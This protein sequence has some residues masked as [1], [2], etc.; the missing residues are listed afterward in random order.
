MDT[1]PGKGHVLAIMFEF[2]VFL[3]QTGGGGFSKREK[4][5]KARGRLRDPSQ[6]VD[7]ALGVWRK[8]PKR[9]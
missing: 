3:V 8:L 5:M 1:T 2:N 6:Q 4:K 9:K 7:R